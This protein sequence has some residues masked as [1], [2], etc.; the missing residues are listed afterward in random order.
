MSEN[1]SFAFVANLLDVNCN[2]PFKVIE[3]CYFQKADFI[4]IG[5]IKKSLLDSGYFYELSRFNLSPYE[6][7]YVEDLNTPNQKA[8]KSQHLEPQNWRYYI[9]TFKG[10]NSVIHDLAQIA[11]LAK[12][13]LEFGLQFIYHE[14]LEGFGILKNP[15]HTFN[16]FNEMNSGLSLTQFIDDTI[17]QDIGSIYLDYK[18]LDETKYSDIK[19]AVNMLNELKNIPHNS[20]FKILGLFTIIE[21]LI[22]HK[23]ID[24]GDSITRQVTNKINLL[25]KRFSNQLDYCQFFVNT[26][27]SAIWKKLYAYRSN[28]AHGSKPDFAKDLLVLKDDSTAQNFLKLVV[29]MLLRHSLIEPQLYT[30]LK[31]C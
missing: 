1:T 7:V 6:L 10:N 15:T 5:Q 29:K 16:Y 22:T 24:T 17:L 26:S 23:P 13:E 9:L 20:K 27:E 4:Q 18:Q 28:I 19:E 21:F 11:N 25:S 3:D 14:Q 8:F 2:L 31:E 30:D 12:I